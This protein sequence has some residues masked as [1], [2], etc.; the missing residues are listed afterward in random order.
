MNEVIAATP[1]SASFLRVGLQLKIALTH[2]QQRTMCGSTLLGWKEH[3][4]LVCEWPS[5]LGHATD[6]L[7]GASCM[8]SYLLDGKLVGYRADIR[9]LV[10]S[11]VPLLF[12]AFPQTVEEMH[13]R[14]HARISS[15]EPVL[16]TRADFGPHVVSVL[17]PS[18]YAGGFVKN[19]SGGGCSIALEKIPV[20]IRP[21]ATIHLEFELPGLGHVTNLA[22]VVKNTEGG[23]GADIIGV[24]FQFDRLEYIEYRGWGGSVR[25]A[26]DQWTAQKSADV[27]PIR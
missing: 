18:D 25:N 20:W 8:V 10:A 14:K 3:A 17:S 23:D 27:F 1:L 13:L 12:L 4:W 21:G 16:L 5:Q 2:D 15:S 7:S 22:G 26:I 19:L 9:D 24:E 11:P 6:I